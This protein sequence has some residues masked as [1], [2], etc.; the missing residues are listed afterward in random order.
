[1][2]TFFTLNS[3]FTLKNDDER[4]T[5]GKSPIFAAMHGGGET[6]KRLSRSPVNE[7]GIRTNFDPDK[8]LSTKLFTPATIGF[9]KK[10]KRLLLASE[11]LF[12]VAAVHVLGHVKPVLKTGL[13]QHP[14]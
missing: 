5:F 12:D 3:V 7:M 14:L 9:Y 2:F 13:V 8:N 1:M 4:A 11:T 6:F 10:R